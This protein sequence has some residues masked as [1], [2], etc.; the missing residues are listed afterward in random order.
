[1]SESHYFQPEAETAPGVEQEAKLLV[2]DYRDRPVSREDPVLEIRLV[3]DHER[4]DRREGQSLWLN[5]G[6]L[7]HLRDVL[8]QVARR[9]DER[10]EGIPYLFEDARDG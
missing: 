8:N 3:S 6:D 9:Y 5:D 4:G 2:A 10:K 7:H 1:M